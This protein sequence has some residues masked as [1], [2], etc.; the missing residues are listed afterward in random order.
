[1]GDK[2]GWIKKMISSR[3]HA[4]G[5]VLVRDAGQL[6]IQVTK[7]QERGRKEVGPCLRGSETYFSRFT[8]K[9][10]DSVNDLAA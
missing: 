3:A 5:T 1:M 9:H 6:K 4:H 2:P 8:W 7:I 10:R